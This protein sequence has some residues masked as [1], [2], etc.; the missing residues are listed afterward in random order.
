MSLLSLTEYSVLGVLAESPAHGFAISKD[1]GPKGFAGRILTVRRPLVYR[2]LD[3]LVAADLATPKRTEA[4]DAG[5][6]RVIYRI[7][8]KGKRT[9]KRWLDEPVEHVREIRIAFQ[10]KLAFL[11]RLRL[12]PRVL[13]DAQSQALGSTLAALDTPDLSRSDHLQLWRHYNSKAAAAYLD[14]LKSLYL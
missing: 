5:P 8:P 3:R 4:G 13:L 14:D 7:T 2:A 9:L 12:S 6:Q 11:D 10:L 1:L